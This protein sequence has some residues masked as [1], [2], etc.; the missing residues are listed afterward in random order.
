MGT[1]TIFE[2]P[3]TFVADLLFFVKQLFGDLLPLILLIAGLIAGFFI[4]ER[5]ISII[6]GDKD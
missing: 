1:T 6:R 2:L 4:I 5:I 3:D